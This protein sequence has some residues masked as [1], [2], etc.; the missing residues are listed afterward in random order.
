MATDYAPNISG[1]LED[2]AETVSDTGATQS[3]SAT[4]EPNV[5]AIA[6]LEIS[7]AWF[8]SPYWY[9]G[10][11]LD[12]GIDEMDDRLEVCFWI[13]SGKSHA[14]NMTGRLRSQGN[15]S[16]AQPTTRDNSPVHDS[17]VNYELSLADRYFVHRVRN[18]PA[19]PWSQM[20]H[21]LSSN[22]QVV[23]TVIEGS[24]SSRQLSPA[25][26]L[27][28]VLSASLDLRMD[29]DVD[30]TIRRSVLVSSSQGAVYSGTANPL[31]LLPTPE[32][33][34]LRSQLIQL[35]TAW[36]PAG[37]FREIAS[38]LPE[39]ASKF[40]PV[41]GNKG[42]ASSDLLQKLALR[43]P[44]FLGL[45][46]VQ[47]H[48]LLSLRFHFRH[49]LNSSVNR[50]RRVH[51]RL[52][53]ISIYQSLWFKRLRGPVRSF[54]NASRTRYELGNRWLVQDPLLDLPM[55]ELQRKSPA[56]SVTS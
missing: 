35:E 43:K 27:A 14:S 53:A 28:R 44:K 3:R 47:K 9:A 55:P 48:P 56:G 46:L 34:W 39:H 30:S 41:I 22:C 32:G 31:C 18:I 4:C 29:L 20:N 6:L 15:S 17:S 49:I 23:C 36:V 1:R 11:Y 25:Q 45:V 5:C 37:I 21:H 24:R 54:L 12:I 10:T 33:R 7:T 16:A 42:L 38:L 52:L 40:V 8:N 2:V 50:F 13:G 51:S 19:D 26:A